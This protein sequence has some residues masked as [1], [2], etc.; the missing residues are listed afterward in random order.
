MKKSFILIAVTATLFAACSE[1]DSFKDVNTQNN[2]EEAISFASYTSKLTRAENSGEGYTWGFYAHQPDFKVYAYKNPNTAYDTQVFSG[3]VIDAKSDGSFDYHVATEARFWDKSPS[4]KYQFYA[5]AP[6][7]GAWDF[8]TTGIVSY[9]TQD[10]GYFETTS[11]LKGNNLRSG[12]I[13]SDASTIITALAEATSSFKEVDDIDKMIAAPCQGSYKDF[14]VANSNPAK[15]A[16]QLD[17]IHILSKMNV[18]VK[19]DALLDAKTVKLLSIEFFNLKN[20]GKFSEATDA[21][22][23]GSYGRWS[24]QA[25]QQVNSANVTYKFENASGVTLDKTNKI[26]FIESLVIPQATATQSVDYDG[27]ILPASNYTYTEYNTLHV[28]ETG[29]TEYTSEEAYTADNTIDK[30]KKVYYETDSEP[31]FKISYTIDGELFTSYH[32]LAG[33]FKLAANSTLDFYEGWQNTLNINIKPEQIDFDADIANWDDNE[34]V[35]D[36]DIN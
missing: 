27:T 6:A 36:A 8:K 17:F 20:Y 12:T 1:T 16:V 31:Y 13:D 18:T 25:K 11:T 29:F 9:A 28:G 3:Q 5:A 22:A 7:N 21:V 4:S 2:G 33:S 19:K 15:H 34:N 26:F 10:K 30:T 23:A 14:L 32:N 24:E 35:E